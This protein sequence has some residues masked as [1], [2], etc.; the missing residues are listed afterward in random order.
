MRMAKRKGSFCNLSDFMAEMK[1]SWKGLSSKE[2]SRI[3]NLIYGADVKEKRYSNISISIN[4]GQEILDER[5]ILCVLTSTLYTKYRQY[6]LS[7]IA[8]FWMWTVYVSVAV[9]SIF[10]IQRILPECSEKQFWLI[11][12]ILEWLKCLFGFLLFLLPLYLVA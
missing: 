9:C 4:L 1:R 10:F 2:W 11:K 6:V 7:P 5:S 8:N 3:N 12:S